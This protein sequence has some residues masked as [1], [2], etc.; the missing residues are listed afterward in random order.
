MMEA[1]KKEKKEPTALVIQTIKSE[2]FT[3]QGN[4]NDKFNMLYY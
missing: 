3:E 4:I 2:T 1:Q